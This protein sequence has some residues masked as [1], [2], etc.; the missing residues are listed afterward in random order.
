MYE[1]SH[2][3]LEV[4]KEEVNVGETLIS[5]Y[6]LWVCYGCNTHSWKKYGKTIN[7]EIK[8]GE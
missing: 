7:M 2:D 3:D 8:I 4:I 6:E 5:I 1:C